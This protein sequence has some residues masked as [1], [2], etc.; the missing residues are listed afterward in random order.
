MDHC[1]GS[2]NLVQRYLGTGPRVSI[3]KFNA[4]QLSITDA[5]A[6][7]SRPTSPFIPGVTGDT[8]TTGELRP[9]T[10]KIANHS[11]W[12]KPRSRAAGSNF[13]RRPCRAASQCRRNVAALRRYYR[14][15]CG[16][17]ARSADSDGRAFALVL[18]DSNMPQADGFSLVA[19]L[20][21]ARELAQTPV[22]VLTSGDRPGD[23]ARGKELGV[24]GH[25]VKPIK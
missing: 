9:W 4:S 11:G 16:R 18:T 3:L 15:R 7:S 24:A 25:L 19:D 1:C 2:K 14:S 10:S 5:T 6:E 8:L 17:R 20:R 22:I 21:G 23:I 12:I 13:S